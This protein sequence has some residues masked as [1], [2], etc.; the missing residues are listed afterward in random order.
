ME[1]IKSSSECMSCLPVLQTTYLF[2]PSL[3]ISQDRHR[4]P[5]DAGSIIAIIVIETYSQRVPGE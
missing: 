1:F 5:S 2:L 3:G 4:L